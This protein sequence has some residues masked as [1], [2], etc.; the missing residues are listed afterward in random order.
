MLLAYTNVMQ[1]KLG[2]MECGSSHTLVSVIPLLIG[3]PILI[4]I[5]TTVSVYV[6]HVEEE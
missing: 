4:F 1:I 5:Y 2:T 3:V 6:F